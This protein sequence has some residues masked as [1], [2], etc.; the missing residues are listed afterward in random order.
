MFHYDYIFTY[1]F[2]LQLGIWANIVDEMWLYPCFPAFYA[3]FLC[4][5]GSESPFKWR[6]IFG[7]E[8]NSIYKSHYDLRPN[9]NQIL[10]LQYATE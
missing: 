10:L 8:N 6:W 4:T 9:V 3:S 2:R 1:F 5:A 7:I